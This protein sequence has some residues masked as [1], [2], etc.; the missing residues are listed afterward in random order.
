MKNYIIGFGFITLGCFLYT[1]NY[2]AAVIHMPS[3]T[4]WLAAEG[5]LKTA[6]ANVGYQPTILGSILFIIGVVLLTGIG[7]RV[8]KSIQT[9]SSKT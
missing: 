6:Y 3:V 5:R 7:Q 8:I 9:P 4:S 2:I 1:V